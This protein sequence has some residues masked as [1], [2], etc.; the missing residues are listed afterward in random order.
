[1]PISEIRKG[2][3]KRCDKDHEENNKRE[4]LMPVMGD[5]G[6]DRYFRD[7]QCENTGRLYVTA[8][9]RPGNSLVAYFYGGVC[10]SGASRFTANIYFTVGG[11]AL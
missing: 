5:D 4:K 10:A 6:N 1:M 7:E 8:R 3:K 2:G 9:K 11:T